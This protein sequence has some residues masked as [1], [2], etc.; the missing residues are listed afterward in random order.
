MKTLAV[1]VKHQNGSAFELA[2]FF[3]KHPAVTTV[4]YPGLPTHP[5]YQRSCELFDGFGG[6]LSIELAGGTAAAERF[7]HRTTLAVIAPSLGGPETLLTRPV[8]TSHAGMAPHD[9][10]RLGI[11]DGLIRISVGLEATDD[12]LEDFDQALQG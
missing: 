3:A 6:M 8:T 10:Q 11:T 2:G 5:D 4:N 7:M 9:R 12:L 1:R